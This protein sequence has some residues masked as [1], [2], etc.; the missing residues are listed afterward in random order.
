MTKQISLRIPDD[1]H[2][3]LKAAA[4]RDSRS[5]HN[6]IL[7]WLSER[8]AAEGQPGDTEGTT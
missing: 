1:M 6:L 5:L 8:L 7:L 2:E 4:Q 3:L